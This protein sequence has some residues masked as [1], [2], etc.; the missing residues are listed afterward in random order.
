M[1]L[2]SLKLTVKIIIR[3]KIK[4]S[5]RNSSALGLKMGMRIVNDLSSSSS[6]HEEN[7]LHSI[8]LTN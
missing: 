7:T 6:S 5:F 8:D 3:C 2:V 1:I 4:L